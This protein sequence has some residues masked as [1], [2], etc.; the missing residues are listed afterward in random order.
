M[1]ASSADSF[2]FNTLGHRTYFLDY[3][4]E[5]THNYEGP[6]KET[7]KFILKETEISDLLYSSWDPIPIEYYTGR[8]VNRNNTLIKES[9][10]EWI[11]IDGT[12]NHY[13]WI[14]M[15]IEDPN[16]SYKL[17]TLLNN[18]LKQWIGTPELPH[19]RFKTDYSGNIF[20][21]KLSN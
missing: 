8:T 14:N 5:L 15:S 4:Y 18:S 16:E 1:S 17:Y 9:V 11:F 6:T 20:V 21:Y 7:V 10:F 19:H 12:P 3:L 2:I 13:Y